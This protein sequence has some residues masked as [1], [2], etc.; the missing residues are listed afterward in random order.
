MRILEHGTKAPV[1]TCSSCSCKFEYDTGDIQVQ[2][3]DK[4]TTKSVTCPECGAT[5]EIEE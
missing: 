5:I 3:T 1:K 2:V 4:K